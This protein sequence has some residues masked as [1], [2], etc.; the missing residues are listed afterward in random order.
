MLAVKF[1]NS[2]NNEYQGAPW[3]QNLWRKNAVAST[4]RNMN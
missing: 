3:S 4:E 1:F 2:S